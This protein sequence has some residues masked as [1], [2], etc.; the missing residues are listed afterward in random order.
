MA[1]VVEDDERVRDHEHGVVDAR[2]RAGAFRQPFLEVADHVVGQKPHGAPAEPGQAAHGDG[3]V[4]GQKLLQDG[5]GV[6]PVG[7]LREAA[8]A[9]DFHLG[10]LHAGDGDLVGGCCPEHPG[11]WPEWLEE[12][13]YF[14]RL[15]AFRERLL[16]QGAATFL[17]A[18][19]VDKALA[20]PKPIS[21]DFVGLRIADRFVF[22]CGMDARGYWRNLPEIRAMKERA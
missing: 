22:G 14:F 20:R 19:L 9:A 11:L 8:V 1:D 7:D 15:S 17:C 2:V 4:P 5:Q 12:E 13:N 18:V 21:A 10:G 16:A 6:S 3:P